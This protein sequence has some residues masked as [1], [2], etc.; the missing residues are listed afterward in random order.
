MA[1]TK[2]KKS[3]VEQLRKLIQEHGVSGMM[4]TTEYKN[5]KER[6]YLN[7]LEKENLKTIIA[8]IN[9]GKSYDEIRFIVEGARYSGKHSVNVDPVADATSEFMIS[10]AAV[11]DSTDPVDITIAG[12]D[13][14]ED[15]NSEEVERVEV[16]TTDANDTT[17]H[18]ESE[19]DNI[20][21]LDKE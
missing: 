21:L 7:K 5:M 13:N 17:V 9:D 20:I 15:D 19:I 6:N 11:V 12:V 16:V 10:M 8:L 1:Q 3:T 18:E 4:D 14:D 2:V